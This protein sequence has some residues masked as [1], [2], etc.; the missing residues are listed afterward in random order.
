MK[1]KTWRQERRRQSTCTKRLDKKCSKEVLEVTQQIEMFA[2][3]DV[4]AV[5]KWMPEAKARRQ[6]LGKTDN[7]TSVKKIDGSH[8]KNRRNPSVEYVATRVTPVRDL[9][10]SHLLHRQC[11]RV[12]LMAA[13]YQLFPCRY[14]R[15]R[16]VPI[17]L[18]GYDDFHIGKTTS[19][20]VDDFANCT[21]THNLA[22]SYRC[23]AQISRLQMAS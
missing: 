23:T 16:Y 6:R 7:A 14:G 3:V 18:N 19:E 1:R 5:S 22:I 15:R 21:L 11:K 17:V 8:R 9:Q 4:A 10:A 12:A 13:H 20:P 2:F